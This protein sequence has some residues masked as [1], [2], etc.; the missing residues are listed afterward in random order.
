MAVF[1]QAREEDIVIN[2][3]DLR[4]EKMFSSG[5]G[6]QNV[7]KNKTAVRLVHLPIAQRSKDRVE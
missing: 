1:P 5:A 2:S 3:K 4:E 7:Q 6:G